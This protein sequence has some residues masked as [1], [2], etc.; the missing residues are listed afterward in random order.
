MPAGEARTGER[1]PF[2]PEAKKALE[3]SLREALRIKHSYIGTEHLLLGLLRRDDRLAAEVSR[4][5][6]NCSGP[7]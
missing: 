3:L 7:G 6:A 2:T 5:T 1:L 4:S